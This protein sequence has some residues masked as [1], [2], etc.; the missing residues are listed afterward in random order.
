MNKNIDFK[1]RQ[2]SLDDMEHVFQL[3]N[4]PYVRK[5]SINPDLITWE[6]HV[7]WYKSKLLS[8]DY[9]FLVAYDSSDQF[10]GQVRF[11]IEQDIATISTSIANEFRGKKLATPLLVMATR[12][13]W[14]H[15]NYINRIYAYI[16]PDNNAS[17]L[18]FKKAG[19]VF[20]QN[21]TLRDDIFGLY[22]LERI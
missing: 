5:H 22:I 14:Q 6:A 13:C 1:L 12:L 19:F 18:A 9:Y 17:V 10:I 15:R 3:S 11:D 16:K 21:K 2:A 20:S 4:E 8:K 7:D